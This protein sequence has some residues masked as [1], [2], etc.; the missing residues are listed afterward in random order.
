MLSPGNLF[1]LVNEVVFVLLGLL[2]VWLVLSGRYFFNRRAPNWIAL[3]AFLVYWGLRVWR[4][5]GRD[6]ARGECAAGTVRGAS[7]LLVGATMLGVA[8]LPFRW[9]A[10]LLAAAGGILVVRGL[11]SAVLVV[12]RL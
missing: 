7:L 2:L 1:R 9:V 10:P 3:G 5:A 8:W 4:R 6:A 11:V 12:R